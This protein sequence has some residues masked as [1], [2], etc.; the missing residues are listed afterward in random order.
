M[1]IMTIVNDIKNFVFGSAKASIYG[2]GRR[3]KQKIVISFT[4]S[5]IRNYGEMEHKFE[6]EQR[7]E[8]LAG[9]RFNINSPIQLGTI[10]F[11]KLGLTAGKKTK[12]GYSTSAETLERILDEHEIVPLILEYRTLTKLNSTYIEGLLPLI[13]KDGKIH[14]HFNQTVTATGRLSCT[15]PNLQNIPIRQ[16]FGRQLRKAFVPGSADY[17]FVGADYSQI[18]L[19]VLAH[20]A[21]DPALIDAFNK[22]EDIHRT[23]AA[24]VLGVL[25]EEI[26]IEERSRAKAVNFGVIYGMSSFG[27]SSELHITRKD[28]DAYIKAYFE[29]HAAVKSFMDEQ[30]QL[31]KE[32]GYVSTILGRK[33]YINEISASNYMVRQVGER[34]AMNSPIQGS[35]ADIIKIAMIKVYQKLRQQGLKSRLILQVHDELIIETEKSE[36]EI[37]E[38]LLR[39]NM[40]QAIELKAKL[41]ADLNQGDSWYDLK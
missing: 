33:R 16:A 9:E 27:L 2:L 41:V 5:I 8:D 3:R 34:L 21:E 10:L 6:K 1:S 14:A 13:D 40:E 17:T 18:E 11:E 12:R 25:P 31:C 38:K 23:T 4:I 30:V 19:R 24:N 29:K 7:W 36:Q 39:E 22:G 20:M 35:A 15:E 28:A 32:Q 37:V 26:T